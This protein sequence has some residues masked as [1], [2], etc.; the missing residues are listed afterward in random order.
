[1]FNWDFSLE[2]GRWFSGEEDESAQ[3]VAV[4]GA[5]VK[6]ELF[7]GLEAVGRTMLIRGLPFRVVGVIP[8]E[9]RSIGF[10]QDQ[11]IYIPIQVYRRNFAAANEDY[12]IY[13][14]ARGGV[15]HMDATMDEVRAF[16]RAMRHT[17]FRDADP[18]GVITQ[19]AL[20]DLWRQI[21]AAAF[22]LMAL[23]ASVSLGVGGVVIMNIMLVSVTERTPEI[24]IRMAMG[25]RKRDIRRQFLL[26]ASLLSLVGG[27]AGVI[28]GSLAAFLV[29]SIAGF[30][31]EVTPL[32]VMLGV[33]LSTL[34]GLAAGFL[35]AR[36]ASNLVVID[37]IRTE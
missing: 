23:V 28:L 29:K 24:G 20:Q 17:S 13:V 5:N 30:P 34:V 37:A 22:I 16:F 26:E 8:K 11:R 2:S 21:S 12:E 36:R 6:D 15:E 9:G 3:M 4:I 10:N 14:K 27:I 31:A 18:F 32:I 19:E 7:P 33:G 1:M 35:P 25:A